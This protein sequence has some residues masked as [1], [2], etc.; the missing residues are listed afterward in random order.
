MMTSFWATFAYF[1]MFIVLE[2]SS[3]GYVEIW[4]AIVTFLC[5][6]ILVLTSFIIDKC[7][8]DK[9]D[10][11]QM[12]EE[13]RAEEDSKNARRQLRALVNKYDMKFVIDCGTGEN[14][15]SKPNAE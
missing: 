5:F 12:S 10:R 14:H 2:V 11:S 3:P 1:W 15:M 7:T 13:E 9:K 8:S 6:I 4:E